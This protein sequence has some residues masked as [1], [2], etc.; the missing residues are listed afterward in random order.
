MT[1][2][3]GSGEVADSAVCSSTPALAAVGLVLM[4]YILLRIVNLT[5]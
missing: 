5:H 1:S 3:D 2:G 4:M